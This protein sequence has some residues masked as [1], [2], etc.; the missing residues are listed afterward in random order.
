MPPPQT[1]NKYDSE[2]SSTEEAKRKRWGSQEDVSSDSAKKSKKTGS[3]PDKK[4]L[5]RTPVKSQQNEDAKIDQILGLLQNLTLEVNQI[6]TDQRKYNEEI[7][8]LK[9]ENETIRKENNVIKK[10]CEEIKTELRDTNTRLEQ[11]E[12]EKRRNN[13]VVSGLIIDN[14]NPADLREGMKNFIQQKLEVSV[15]IKTA[16][17]IGP[18]M[19][20]VQLESFEDKVKLM[21]N[22]WK[23]KNMEGDKVFFNND[24]T[25]KEREGDKQIRKKAEEERKQGK[26]VKIGYQKVTIEGKEWRW[27]AD[28]NTLEEIKSKENLNV[29]NSKN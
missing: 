13:V 18:K 27:S 28:K 3:S 21:Q 4:K 6:R 26:T 5:Y 20:V 25:R 24:L 12:R 2:E 14:S 8:K 23:L 15:P 7:N 22:K 29:N 10:E 9:L 19:C 11:L 16:Y 17:K 1:P